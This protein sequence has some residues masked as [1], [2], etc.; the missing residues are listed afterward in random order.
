[1]GNLD[2]ARKFIDSLKR[3]GCRFSL[4]D[5]GSGFSNFTYLKNL[6]ID[7]LKIDGSFIENML[8][9]PINR[10]MVE[11]INNIGHSMKMKTVAE[12][13]SSKGL[14]EELIE[15]GID[16]LQGYNIC[17]PTPIENLIKQ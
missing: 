16:Y 3:V 1:M 13:V 8:D 2:S 14:Q 7:Y 12:F 9:D 6:D 5:F 15:L 10:A 17:K 4:D 11:S